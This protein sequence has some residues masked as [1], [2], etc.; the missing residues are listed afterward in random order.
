MNCFGCF[1]GW[2]RINYGV[3][4]WVCD[5]K[6][7]CECLSY[8]FLSTVRIV[9][10]RTFRNGVVRT[11]LTRMENINRMMHAD[12]ELKHM[13]CMVVDLW[14]VYLHLLVRGAFVMKQPWLFLE[15]RL[16][17]KDMWYVKALSCVVTTKTIM[18]YG[19]ISMGN[20]L[21]ESFLKA[22]N[23]HKLISKRWLHGVMVWVCNILFLVN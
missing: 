9:G 21:E 16:L 10:R 1:Y 15:R 19:T 11:W 2:R 18:I 23:D 6:C 3:T 22:T 5:G 8:Y 12:R 14:S 17:W 7:V 20:V 4:K 13:W